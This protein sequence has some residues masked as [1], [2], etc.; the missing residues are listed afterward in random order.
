MQSE[1]KEM[2]QNLFEI[3]VCEHLPKMGDLSVFIENEAFVMIQY[4]VCLLLS[5]PL[6]I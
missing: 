1:K 3:Y 5:L 6:Q 2:V 4:K